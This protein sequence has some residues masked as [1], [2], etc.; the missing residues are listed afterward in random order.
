VRANPQ[1]RPVRLRAGALGEN[2]PVRDL[3]VSPLHCLFVDG[4]LVPAGALVNGDSIR[5]EP[6][7]D[8]A[9]LHL[10][11]DRHE[12]LLA[13][14]AAAES[15]SDQASRGLFDNAAEFAA[16]YP[17]APMQSPRYPRIEHG[18]MFEAVLA[19]LAPPRPSLGAPRGHV[20]RIEGGVIEGWAMD[21]ADPGARVR[22]DI[23]A[24]GAPPRRIIAGQYRIDL[25]AAG[26][27]DGS[28]GFQAPV[29]TGN[30]RVVR[31]SDGAPL[32]L[33]F[34]AAAAAA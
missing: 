32:P 17:T 14:G 15:F 28:C 25:D 19:R 33:A 5:R 21:A 31:A 22:L 16:L 30:I 8:V 10:E 2:L 9:Y 12:L 3:L 20:E 26:L 18:A 6:P 7:A 23:I 34:A 4:I 24:D 11:L 13:E 27:A 29:T 1:L